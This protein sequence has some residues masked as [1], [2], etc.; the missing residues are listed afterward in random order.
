[1]V[2]RVLVGDIGGTNVRF[3]CANLG[4][5]GCAE[6]DNVTILPGD[7]FNSFSA[8]LETYLDQ[9][10]SERPTKALFALAGPVN[11]GVVQLT[12]RKDWRVNSRLLATELG[13]S[14]VELVNDYAA[15]AR[16]I[17]ELP[18]DCFRVLHQGNPTSDRAPILVGGPGT[19]L[20]IATLIPTGTSS[21]A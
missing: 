4:D 16:S 19:G 15:M 10:G 7:D 5:R 13:F 14:S 18:D 12:H 6:I 2:E 1:M 9:L 3:A 20:G 8:A 11:D 17:P 21:W